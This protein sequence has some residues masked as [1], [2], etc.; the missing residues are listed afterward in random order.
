MCLSPFVIVTGK[1]KLKAHGY[2]VKT[3]NNI[4]LTKVI[5]TLFGYILYSKHLFTIF[6]SVLHY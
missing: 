6:C 2:R 1:V 5:K 3:G 4:M